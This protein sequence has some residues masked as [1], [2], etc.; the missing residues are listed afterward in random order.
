[1]TTK[2]CVILQQLCHAYST[3]VDGG[4]HLC[5][6]QTK[7]SREPCFPRTSPT[8]RDYPVPVPYMW[9]TPSILLVHI[10]SAANP[11]GVAGQ[12]SLSW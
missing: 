1:M 8:V 12:E 2:C 4:L 7:G 11:V 10:L 9:D 6:C 3:A 5:P